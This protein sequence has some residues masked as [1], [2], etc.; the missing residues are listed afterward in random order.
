MAKELDEKVIFLVEAIDITINAFIP[1]T[2]FYARSIPG[3]DKNYK[4]A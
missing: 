3:F 2:K 4:D 1:K